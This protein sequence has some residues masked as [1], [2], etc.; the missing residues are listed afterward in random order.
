MNSYNSFASVKRIL[1]LCVGIYML[2]YYRLPFVLQ[3]DSKFII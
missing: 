1:A 2:V 3:D